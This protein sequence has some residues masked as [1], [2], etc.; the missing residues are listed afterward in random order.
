MS[1]AFNWFR[2]R[3]LHAL[4]LAIRFDACKMRRLNRALKSFTEFPAS[5]SEQISKRWIR[6]FTEVYRGV[7][8]LLRY[9]YGRQEMEF[10]VFKG[11]LYYDTFRSNRKKNPWLEIWA[12]ACDLLYSLQYILYR[13]HL[14]CRFYLIRKQNKLKLRWTISIVEFYRSLW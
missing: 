8:R 5:T 11:R 9:T 1:H 4:N 12:Q 7:T 2:R 13:G 10:W 6:M 14:L 3:I